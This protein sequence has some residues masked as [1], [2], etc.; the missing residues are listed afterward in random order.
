MSSPDRDAILRQMGI[1]QWVL[2]DAPP[3]REPVSKPGAESRSL[4]RDPTDPPSGLDETAPAETI[5]PVPR[6]SPEEIGTLEDLRS[7]VAACTACELAQS[8]TLTVFGEG[9]DRADWMFIGEAP[10]QQE[11][12]QGKPFVGRAGNLLT[13]MLLALG[14][15]REQ[16][17]I[18]NTLKCRPPRNRDPQPQE[19]QACEQ[20]LLR[21]I[22]LVQPSVLVALGRFSAQALTASDQSLSRLRGR[23]HHYGPARIP[24][25]VTYHPAY[26][27]RQP[28]DKAKAWSD[29][30][31]AHRQL[32]V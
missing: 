12:M 13:Q 17:F 10:G 25:V 9:P 2:R 18:A 4:P 27:L 1:T 3:G 26:L 28:A 19:L 22:E 11:D 21:Q 14:L 31:L 15:K 24:L 20:F 32:P 7:R 16:V 23:V 29:L 8:R 30:L 5:E 6:T